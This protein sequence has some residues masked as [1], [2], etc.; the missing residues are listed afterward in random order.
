MQIKYVIR[1]GTNQHKIVMYTYLCAVE[2]K[3]MRK[4]LAF[5]GF[6][7]PAKQVV[8]SI[9]Y[10]AN[11]QSVLHTAPASAIENS[12]LQVHIYSFQ[13]VLKGLHFY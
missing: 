2:G 11:S 5:C 13:L 1:C 12:H 4:S 8:E 6:K 9:Q 10:V 7:V 3:R